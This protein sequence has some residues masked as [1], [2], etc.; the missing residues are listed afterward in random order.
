MD[1]GRRAGPRD[2][3][4]E[5]LDQVSPSPAPV[6]AVLAG[7][8]RLR[9][10]RRVLAGAGAAAVAAAAVTVAFV[11][12]G[13]GHGGSPPAG[14][15]T[16]SGPAGS[17]VIGSGSI[18]GQ[19]WQVVLDQATGRVCAGVIGLRRSCVAPRGPGRMTGL[20][21]LSGTWVPTP[22]PAQDAMEPP[23]W[24]AFFGP[25]RADLTRIV[26][27]SSLGRSFDLRPVAV[28]G[29]RWVGVVLPSRGI[30]QIWAAAYAGRTELGYSVPFVGGALREGTYFVSWLRPGQA[31]PKQ[32]TT[33]IATGGSG[34]SG[35]SALVL[36]GPWGYCVS[37]GVPVT[38]GA[39]QSCF[40][41]GALRDSAKIIMRRGSPPAEPRWIIG[42]ARPDV[43]YIE[44]TLVG[45]ATTRVAVSDVSGQ[46]FYAMQIGRGRTIIGWGAFNA[47]G[48]R[49]YGGRGAPD[50]GS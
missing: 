41:V 16:P 19:P 23:L 50:S 35:W 17:V 46:R 48:R 49:L 42:T 5:A 27:R 22:G 40:A 3:L 2:R 31:G 1:S 43:A 39:E 38:D 10:R 24:D 28:A 47:A 14:S 12:P 6:D 34:S 44:L 4:S 15:P 13:A 33:Y 18:G 45:G 25:V 9:N 8:A 20:A 37:L 36:A 32:V 26:I 11:L 7:A 21:S 29:R 30:G